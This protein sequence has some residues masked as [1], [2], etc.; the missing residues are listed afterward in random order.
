MLE[1]DVMEESGGE[2]GSPCSLVLESG[3]TSGFYADDHQI[4]SVAGA[5]SCPVTGVVD[6]VEAICPVKDVTELDSWKG[7][8]SILWSER[9]KKISVCVDPRGRG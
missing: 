8:W 2:C 9:T 3:G 1:G 4:D 5:D 7:S 6:C